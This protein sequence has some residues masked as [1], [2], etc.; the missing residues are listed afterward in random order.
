MLGFKWYLIK[1]LRSFRK[2]EVAYQNFITANKYVFGTRGVQFKCFYKFV[3]THK[4]VL[5]ILNTNFDLFEV[6]EGKFVNWLRID[7]FD[8]ILKVKRSYYINL[9]NEKIERIEALE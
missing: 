1:T 4:C 6:E 5:R 8:K 9:E 7:T 2:A 3:E